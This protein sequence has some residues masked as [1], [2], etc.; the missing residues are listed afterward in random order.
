MVAHI[1]ARQ[2]RRIR[3]SNHATPMHIRQ[4]EWPVSGRLVG[5]G[6]MATAERFTADRSRE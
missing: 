3:H 2:E 5:S 1:T 6:E 4:Y